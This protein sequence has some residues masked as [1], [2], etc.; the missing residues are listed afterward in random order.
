M[1]TLIFNAMALAF[2]AEA[3]AEQA[4]ENEVKLQGDVFGQ[5]PAEVDPS[6]KKAAETLIF[7][8]ERIHKK[9]IVAL[10]EK[11]MGKTESPERW[12]HYAAMQSMGTGVGLSDYDVELD[13]PYIQFG[14][15]GLEKDYF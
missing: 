2:F 3:F 11:N 7:D 8:L 14:S 1:R 9:N 10:Y 15:Y 13:I 5:L 4:G 12:G 6:A